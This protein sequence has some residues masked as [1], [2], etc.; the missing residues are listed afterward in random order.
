M[1]N[2][3]KNV[4][5]ISLALI[6]TFP[7]CKV[8]VY[9]IYEDQPGGGDFFDESRIS[10]VTALRDWKANPFADDYCELAYVGS[11]GL[12]ATSEVVQKVVNAGYAVGYYEELQALGYTDVTYPEPKAMKQEA[13]TVE[14]IEPHTR[15]LLFYAGYRNGPSE[16]YEKIG[17]LDKKT[18]VTV[19]GR[20]ATGSYYKNVVIDPAKPYGGNNIKKQLLTGYWYE[21]TLEDGTKAYLPQELLCEG[22][23]DDNKF[24]CYYGYA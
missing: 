21:I 7:I 3:L 15:W 1:K 16:A 2:I 20:V 13:Y 17:Y 22:S 9:A 23:P 18:A 19:T 4:V 10:S 8:N 11:N 12:H 24:K 5:I 14:P 6:L